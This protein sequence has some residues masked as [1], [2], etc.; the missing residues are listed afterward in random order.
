MAQENQ[1]QDRA[2]EELV[3]ISDQEKIGLSNY[4]ITLEKP[5][6]EF[7]YPICLDIL[8]QYSFF[9][10]FTRTTDITPKDLDHL[11]VELPPH[12]G[13]IVNKGEEHP[14]QRS[15]KR[16][17]YERWY[18]VKKTET[19]RVPRKKRTKTV[20]EETGQSEEL[21]DSENLEEVEATK[22]ERRLNERHSS[23]VIGREVNMETDEGTYDHSTMKLKGLENYNSVDSRNEKIAK[24]LELIQEKVMEQPARPPP[25]PSHT[26][27]S[28][29]YSNQLIN[30]NVVISMKD[31]LQDPIDTETQS[32]VDV[33]PKKSKEK[34]NAEAVLKRLIKV[35]KKVDAMSK[36]DHTKTIDK[37]QQAHLKKVLPKSIP[38]FVIQNTPSP[39][40]TYDALMDSL[41]VDE[42]DIDKRYK[43][44]PNLKK[45]HHND[46]DPPADDNKGTKKRRKDTDASSSKKNKDQDESLKEA[47]THLSHQRLT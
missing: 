41:L 13:L 12:D 29:E 17:A 11:F 6:P 34:V 40:E 30:D 15:R 8:K 21:A 27:S 2:D 18:C 31:I 45:R 5:Q 43:V 10:V 22:E 9:N 47:K 35:E 20:V 3:P 37:S 38:D 46:K 26:L 36:I 28:A 39:S 25:S 23:L 32:M 44:Q 4:K 19:I 16:A 24:D 14:R 33:L 1:Q 7:I 42:D